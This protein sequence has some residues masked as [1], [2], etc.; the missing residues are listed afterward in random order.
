MFLG[1]IPLRMPYTLARFPSE[2]SP[3]VWGNTP[4]NGRFNAEGP[5]LPEKT[6]LFLNER[7]TEDKTMCSRSFGS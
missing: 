5:P 3:G 4:R 6:A 1:D 7:T 2:P